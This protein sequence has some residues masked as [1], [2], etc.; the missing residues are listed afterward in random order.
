MSG[1][2]P[3]NCGCLK[4]ADDLPPN[5]MTFA[6][7]FSQYAYSTCVCGKL[8][9][10]GSDQMQGWGL[11][12]GFDN[13]VD[14]RR[15]LDG[16]MEDEDKKY[17]IPSRWWPWDKEVRMSG[18]GVSPYL[19]RDEIAVHGA[20]QYI[21]EYFVNSFYG[22]TGDHRPLL[23]KVS[24]TLPHYPFVTEK[25]LFDYY[26]E[27]VQPFIDEQVFDHPAITRGW[28]TV[29]IGEQVSE[30]DVRRATAAYCGMIE[31]LDSLFGE[32]LDALEQ[33]G[34]DLDDWLVIYTSDH[35]EMLGQHGLWM[36]YKFFE[37]SARVPLIIRFPKSFPASKI[38]QNVN[39]CD[40]FA[41]LCDFA[42]IPAPEGLDSRSLVPMLK[43]GG[44]CPGWDNEAI[45]QIDNDLMIKQDHLKYQLFERGQEVL[46]DLR[47]DPGETKDFSPLHEYAE[48]IARFRSRAKQLGYVINPTAPPKQTHTIT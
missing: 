10:Y 33:A 18:V 9:H 1:K 23:L 15:F 39:L 35:G 37:A 36:K 47:R 48:D 40:L 19:G 20:K 44:K 24:L 30:D 32:V 46:F 5:Y 8:H 13:E 16:F 3:K 17:E 26:Y 4:Y 2:L 41:T 45:S 6:K 27:K 11:R 22:K 21:D 28:D 34:Q 43:S 12:I 14:H 31:K 42:G 7:R 29:R 25:K 38:N